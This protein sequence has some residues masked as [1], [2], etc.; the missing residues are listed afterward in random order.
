LYGL[1]SSGAFVPGFPKYYLEAVRS[2]PA[3]ADVNDD[4]QAEIFVGTGTFYYNHSPDHPTIG[5]RV[6]GM[7]SAG[8]TLPGWPVST[9]GAMPASPAIGDIAGDSKP[10]IIIPS[11]DSRIYAFYA[12][13]QPVSGFPMTPR[14]E[15]GQTGVQFTES[16]VLGDYDGDGKMEIFIN[17]SWSVTVVDG[18]GQQLTGD[19]FPNNTKPIYYAFGTLLN[20]PA[21]G[22]IDNDGRLE[23][24]VQNSHLYAWDLASASDAADWPLFK[25]DARRASTLP[26]PPRL[27]LPGEA[28]TIMH[29]IDQQTDPQASIRLANASEQAFDWSAES[30]GTNLSVA[31]R[32]GT[33]QAGE[34]QNVIV[35]I[36]T[37]H[38][39]EGL[40]ELG[41]IQFEATVDG[42]PILGSPDAMTINL[43]LGD[44]EQA[45]IPM[46]AI[47]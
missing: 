35:T 6:Y 13:G 31:P 20:S 38:L 30:V 18:N 32:Y 33:L 23:L 16:V 41:N 11:Y 40:H 21:V 26:L 27:V 24:I 1:T 4:G 36:D 28:I 22:D 47:R 46:L 2:T 14:R 10:E 25:R 8:Q 45:F 9:G 12:N 42:E 17:N 34:T 15:Q 29:P 43:L 37:H 3:I 19:N 44:I 5:Y 7:N 39:S